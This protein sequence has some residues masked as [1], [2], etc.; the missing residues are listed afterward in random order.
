M[1]FRIPALLEGGLGDRWSGR[2][3]HRRIIRVEGDREERDVGF[4]AVDDVVDNLLLAQA[5][6]V[7]ALR[8]GEVKNLQ[9][10]VIF[11]GLRA[12]ATEGRNRG[13]YRGDEVLEAGLVFNIDQ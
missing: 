11:L 9:A 4:V 8:A 12:A 10:V 7:V 6:E 13:G 3:K 5:H 1:L 2:S